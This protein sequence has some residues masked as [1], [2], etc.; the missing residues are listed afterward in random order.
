MLQKIKFIA[1]YRVAP[2]SA[3]THVAQVATIEKWKDTN[4]YV[5]NFTQP[6]M[7]IGPIRLVPKGQVK[8]PQGPRY[9]SKSRLDQAKTLDDVF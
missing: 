1:A 2:E 3:I 4:K 9:T 6:A 8:A 7:P 5:V